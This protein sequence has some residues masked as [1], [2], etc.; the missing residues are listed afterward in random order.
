[1]TEACTPSISAPKTISFGSSMTSTGCAA[2]DLI[3]QFRS[4]L[5]GLVGD[6]DSAL[7]NADSSGD[8][9]IGPSG[10]FDIGSAIGWDEF[11][12]TYLER[13]R[14]SSKCIFFFSALL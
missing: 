11:V 4:R 5:L 7:A 14:L 13:Q 6:F 2:A 10:L 9:S 12:P 3:R 8:L 1:M